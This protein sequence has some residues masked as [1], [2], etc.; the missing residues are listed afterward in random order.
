MQDQ[1]EADIKRAQN[2]ADTAEFAKGFKGY[3]DVYSR[4]KKFIQEELIDKDN[5]LSESERAISK[6]QREALLGTDI[7]AAQNAFSQI[8]SGKYGDRF[9][10][11]AESFN[12]FMDLEQQASSTMYN[13]ILSDLAVAR[14]DLT[15]DALS[16]LGNNVFD[17]LVQGMEKYN[18]SQQEIEDYAKAQGYSKTLDGYGYVKKDE[19]GEILDQLDLVTMGNLAK[20]N[21]VLNSEEYQDQVDAAIAQIRKFG[22]GRDYD[23]GDEGFTKKEKEN[24]EQ[25]TDA[26]MNMDTELQTL[27]RTEAEAREQARQLAIQYINFNKGLKDLKDNYETYIPLL[28]KADKTSMD[29]VNTI[30]ELRNDLSLMLDIKT[31]SLS[32]GFFENIKAINAMEKAAKG[33]ATALQELTELAA[34]DLLDQGIDNV[35]ATGAFTTQLEDQYAAILQELQNSEQ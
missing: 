14:P 20:A 2:L 17:M 1:A 33:S 13:A 22:T 11:V 31:D 25:Y 26:L 15:P 9:T 4:R 30:A 19:N 8:S 32:D 34:V 16:A 27:G 21:Y 3:D 12:D 28:R 5:L 6:E 29:Y 23:R 24:V 10:A 18:P 7:V 35:K